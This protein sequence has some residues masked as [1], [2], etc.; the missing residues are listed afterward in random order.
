MKKEEL[1][2][3]IIEKLYTKFRRP[4]TKEEEINAE[5]DY[6]ILMPI[7]LDEIENLEKRISL[8]EKK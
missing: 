7:V 1:R 3:K 4:P 8:L 2:K 5:T 6:G